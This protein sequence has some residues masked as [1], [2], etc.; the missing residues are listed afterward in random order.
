MSRQRP[1]ESREDF[2]SRM[3]DYMHLRY[4]DKM[5]RAIEAL[6][7]QCRKCGA[8]DGLEI[9]HID[10]RTKSFSVA[11]AYGKG[12]AKFF[13][14]IAKC[15]L[16]CDP[17]HTRKTILD[18]GW[19]SAKEEHGTPRS[20]RYCHCAICKAQ[21]AAKMAEFRRKHGRKRKDGSVYFP[22]AREA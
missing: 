16:L 20:Y 5:A 15:Q 2:N 21:Q 10:P 3:R 14:E 4:V 18:N 9:D 19:Q 12:D 6:G 1:D 7:G 22:K 11:E 8:T 17:C 13:A